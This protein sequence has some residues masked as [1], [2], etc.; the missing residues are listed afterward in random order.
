SGLQVAEQLLRSLPDLKV[1]CVTGYAA[2]RTLGTVRAR[3]FGLLQKP[4]TTDEL[5]R[6]V[7]NVLDGRT[8]GS[9]PAAR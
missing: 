2:H 5:A 7:R 9:A 6:R 8:S 3:G 1:L 4:F